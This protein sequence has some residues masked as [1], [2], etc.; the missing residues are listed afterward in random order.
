MHCSK[1]LCIY[2]V[3]STSCVHELSIHVISSNLSFGTRG[4]FPGWGTVIGWSSL[5]NSMGC[6]DQCRYF[7]VIGGNVTAKFT[8]W[9]M[10][11]SSLFE[12]GTGCIIA[13]ICPLDGI[14]PPSLSFPWLGWFWPCEAPLFVCWID[15]GALF[16]FPSYPCLLALA[17]LL[18]ATS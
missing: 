17:Y 10:L 12:F 11:F 6:S 14:Y 9:V 15:G 8:W 2:Q 16:V 7:M 4:M 18:N 13:I 3:Y 1:C 5:L